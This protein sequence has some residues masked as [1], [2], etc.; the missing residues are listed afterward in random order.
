MNAVPR[1]LQEEWL[2][3]LPPPAPGRDTIVDL[4]AGWCSLRAAVV[5]RGY[6]YIG[7]DCQGDRNLKAAKGVVEH[8]EI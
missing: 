7:V 1:M 2:D 6:N 8:S 5:E 3:S 4:C